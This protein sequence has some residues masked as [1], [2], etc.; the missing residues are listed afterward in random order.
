MQAEKLILETDENGNLIAV[1]KLPAKARFE[2]IFLVLDETPQ[3]QRRKA[4]PEIAGKGRII[5][6]ILSPVV[7]P[8]D[9]DALR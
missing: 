7:A 1:P 3:R 2:A 9:W 8:D 4:P 5:G 6:D